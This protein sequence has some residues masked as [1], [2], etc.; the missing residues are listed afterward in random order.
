MNSNDSILAFKPQADEALARIAPLWPLSRF[1]AVN[2]FVGLSGMPFAQ[3]AGVLARNAGTPLA[4]PPS[5]YRE[6]QGAG[7]ITAEDLR[8][9]IGEAHA[10]L[11]PED[12]VVALQ[13]DIWE[14]PAASPGLPSARIDTESGT[15][16]GAFVTE[17]ISKWCTAYFDGGQALWG[18]PWKGQPL[19]TAWQQAAALDRNPET[20][21]L[22]GWRNFV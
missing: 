5:F 20:A 21:G 19:F 1:V 14:L 17:E 12:L 11:A 2:P 18:F 4:L 7:K 13:D 16:W 3:A 8:K 15:R 9:A 10:D 6:L 22:K